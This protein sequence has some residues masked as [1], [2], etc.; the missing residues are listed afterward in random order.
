[1]TSAPVTSRSSAVVAAVRWRLRLLDQWAPIRPPVMPPTRN[2]PSAVRW[3]DRDAAGSGDP[4]AEE[5]DVAGHVRDEDVAEL[6]VARCVDESG[7]HGQ[8]EQQRRERAV[9]CCPGKGRWL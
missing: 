7:Y 2:E 8:R 4:E 9:W 6:Q 3:P 1:M 5:D